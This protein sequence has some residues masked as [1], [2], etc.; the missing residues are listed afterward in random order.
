[1]L[2]RLC[3]KRELFV[4]ILDD[5]V[6]AA[7][8]SEIS[9]E[10][11][12]KRQQRRAMAAD[13]VLN[14]PSKRL[15]AA[16]TV[17]NDVMLCYDGQRLHDTRELLLDDACVNCNTMMERDVYLSNLVCPSCGHQRHY[18]DTSV[19]DNARG[20]GNQGHHNGSNVPVSRNNRS[21]RRHASPK[22]MTHYMN[23]LNV[24]QGKSGKT[25][26]EKFIKDMCRECWINGARKGSDITKTIIH[27]CQSALSPKGTPNYTISMLLLVIM[28]GHV[29]KFPPQLTKKMLF[30]FSPFWSMYLQYKHL[31]EPENTKKRDRANLSAFKFITRMQLKLHG[32]DVYLDTIESF[33]MDSSILKHSL[34]LRFLFGKLGWVWDDR[35]IDVTD[36]DLD[37][38]DAEAN[39]SRA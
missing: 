24:C 36:E 22:S 39:A 31:L 32:Y 30:V 21:G 38:F 5:V 3:R 25:F 23:Y 9:I 4:K 28:R 7:Q 13:K 34:F 14:A 1:M 18:V 2:R 17:I 26:D 29:T 6:D 27:R 15:F 10:R 11:A 35:I 8:M 33:K 20:S 12:K 16:D 37:W 19:S